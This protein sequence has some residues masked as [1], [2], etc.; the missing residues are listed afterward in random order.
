MSFGF[1]TQSR[2]AAERKAMDSD[3]ERERPNAL[4][5]GSSR[6]AIR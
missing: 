1:L 5:S 4:N 2:R 3:S 6:E